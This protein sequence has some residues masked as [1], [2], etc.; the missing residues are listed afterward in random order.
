MSKSI[1][2]KL[3]YANTDKTRTISIDD[4]SNTAAIPNT[5]RAKVNA[6]NA[7]LAGGTAS[8]LASI[9]VSDD[10]DSTEGIGTLEKITNVEIKSV[11]ETPITA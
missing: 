9:F 5:V 4:V 3:N 10:F 6:I 7:S 8:E 2:F 11:V 1:S